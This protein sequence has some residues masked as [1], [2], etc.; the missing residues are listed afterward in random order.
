VINDY[1][2]SGS[3]ATVVVTPNAVIAWKLMA[4]MRLRGLRCP[5]D[6]SIASFSVEGIGAMGSVPLTALEYSV[7]FMARKAMAAMMAVI[8]GKKVAPIIKIPTDLVIRDSCLVS[9][10]SHTRP[11]SKARK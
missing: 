3:K 5:E 4:A 8:S 7:D 10:H 6:I 9:S 2:D 11:I 1:L